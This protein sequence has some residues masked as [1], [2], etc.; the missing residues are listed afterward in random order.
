MRSTWTLAEELKHC[1][2]VRAHYGLVYDQLPSRHL[3]HAHHVTVALCLESVMRCA[4][5]SQHMCGSDVCVQVSSSLRAREPPVRSRQ[6]E[7]FRAMQR[8]E[9]QRRM[10]TRSDVTVAM[11]VHGIAAVLLG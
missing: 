9:Q 10:L 8:R 3:P 5:D 11:Y 7:L 6:V 1:H 4:C 2:V